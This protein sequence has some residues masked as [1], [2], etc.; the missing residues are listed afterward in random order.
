MTSRTD[1]ISQ[2]AAKTN[3]PKTQVTRVIEAYEGAITGSMCSG[4]DV[5]L[6]GFGTFQVKERAG[7]PGRNLRT[8][9]PIQIPARTAATFKPAK[10]LS[11][12]VN[13]KR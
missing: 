5:K 6:P 10:A 12:R 9:E 4:E 7:R 2:V 1:L 8:G 11:E 13:R 3:L